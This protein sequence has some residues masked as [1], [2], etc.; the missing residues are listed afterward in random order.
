MNKA[1][2]IALLSALVACREPHDSAVDG[3]LIITIHENGKTASRG[4]MRN[5]VIKVGHWTYWHDNEQK[6]EE[7]TFKDGKK[8][9]DWTLTSA[10]GVAITVPYAAG[11]GLDA[12]WTDH[13][14]LV[15]GKKEGSWIYWHDN[16]QKSFAGPTKNGKLDGIWT[17]WHDNG[18]K[19]QEGSYKDGKIDG[20][21]IHWHENGERKQEGTYTNGKP[22]GVFSHW[23]DKG[24]ATKTETYKDGKLVN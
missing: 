2:G 5:E 18:K 1:L 17:F 10:T 19:R 3:K 7:G 12:K 8:E 21:W 23:D 4:Y 6:S 11:V 22:E 15:D 16:G 20:A 24:N 13:G 14:W 9:G